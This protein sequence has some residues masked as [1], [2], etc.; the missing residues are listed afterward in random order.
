MRHPA[1]NFDINHISIKLNCD[2]FEK[3]K[4]N[5]LENRSFTQIKGSRKKS[6][7]FSGPTTKAFTP[8]PD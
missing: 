2:I 5:E 4:D 1:R 7:F 8:P 6:S 3:N